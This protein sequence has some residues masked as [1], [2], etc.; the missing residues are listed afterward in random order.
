MLSCSR[1]LARDNSFSSQEQASAVLMTNARPTF[2]DQNWWVS[3][4]NHATGGRWAVA[5]GSGWDY[6]TVEGKAASGE[7]QKENCRALVSSQASG[8]AIRLVQHA[9]A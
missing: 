1:Q 3:Y 8:S 7:R 4:L 2:F 5:S 9:I 6:A